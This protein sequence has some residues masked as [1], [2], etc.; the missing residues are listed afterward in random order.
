[1]SQKIVPQEAVKVKISDYR[2]PEYEVDPR[3]LNRWSPRA[4]TGE[5][6][7]KEELL[8]LFEAARWAPSSYNSQPW[9]F[10]HAFRETPHWKTFFELLADGNKMWVKNAAVIVLVVSK[11]TFDH[12]GQFSLT[13]SFDAGAAWENLALQGSIRGLVVHGMVGFD[14]DRAKTVLKVP[15]DFNVEA[16]FA[17]G[18]PGRVEDLP[19]PLRAREVPSSRKTVSEIAWEGPFSGSGS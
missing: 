10:L 19:E 3:F 18:R 17:V 4:M 9:R 7:S 15:E 11:K 6:I 2:K 13:H 16:M 1:M 14:Y 5:K 8:S 12:N